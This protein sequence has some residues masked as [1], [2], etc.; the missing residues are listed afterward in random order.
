MST[1]IHPAFPKA[2]RDKEQQRTGRFLE[3]V[4]LHRFSDGAMKRVSG[5]VAVEEPL[6]LKVRDHENIS[7]VRTPGDD[8]N[9]VAGRLLSLGLIRSRRDIR[10]VDLRVCGESTLARVELTPGENVRFMGAGVRREETITVQRLF[11]LR[12]RF[13]ERQ[14][15]F[16]S[17]RATHAAALFTMDGHMLAFGEDVGR[18]NAFDKALGQALHSDCLEDAAIAMLSSRLALE[19]AE[20]ASMAGIGILCGFSVATSSALEFAETRDITLVGR[21]RSTSM[22]IYSHA[23]RVRD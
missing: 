14:A 6:V 18:H 21:L 2:R 5:L 22:N 8:H 20:K 3:S 13:E 7:F 23:W 16:Q 9:L 19:L 12:D 15:L 11:E 1:L 17:T 10:S 4:Q